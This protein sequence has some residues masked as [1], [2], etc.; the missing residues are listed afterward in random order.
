VGL[1][2]LGPDPDNETQSDGR[3]KT[4]DSNIFKSSQSNVWS[5]Q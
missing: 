2:K 4:L 5:K 1:L 3:T